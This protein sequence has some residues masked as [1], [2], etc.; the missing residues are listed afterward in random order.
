MSP[1]LLAR[2]I[3]TMRVEDLGE[4]NLIERLAETV[5]AE[6][7]GAEQPAKPGFRLRLSIGDDAAAWD[8][9]A[10][11]SVL[12]SDA[13]VEGVHFDLERIG[14]WDLGWKA[15]AINLSDIAAMGCAPLYSVVTLGLR[16][17]LA[18]A[19]LVEMYRGMVEASSQHGC[20]IVGGDTVRSPVV[21]LAITMTGAAHGL[22][23]EG[24]GGGALLTRRSASP[25]DKIAVTGSLGCSGGGLRALQGKLAL[26]QDTSD[27]LMAA[28]HRPTPRVSDGM[29]L[30]QHGV[31]AAIDVSDGLVDDLGK[32]C[33]AS[34]VG[35]RIHSDLVPVDEYLRRAYPNDW[36]SLALSG[37]ED[38][39]LLFTATPQTMEV[40]A[41]LLDVPVSII[42][43]IVEGP[44]DV[45][46][47]DESGAPMPVERA[48]WDHFR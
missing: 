17:D 18:I 46:V 15:I 22:P 5:R 48:G 8:S 7:A 40:V 2:I 33:K 6:A 11:T 20:A 4:F 16:G 44:A 3:R 13:M 25:G 26:D 42:G 38:Y 36:L 47:L 23:V 31:A 10:G 39:E 21:F 37:G 1:L 9:P 29:V 19:G 27:H 12:T 45:A 32:L 30:A 41:P 35:A 28:H 24:N 34:G 43:D 14:W